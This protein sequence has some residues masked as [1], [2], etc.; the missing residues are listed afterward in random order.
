MTMIK[1]IL[2]AKGRGYV[3]VSPNETVYSA[4]EKMAEKNIG[5][6]SLW[7][8]QRSPVSSLN[9]TMHATLY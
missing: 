5:S 8:G 6:L 4:L 9:V 1:Q 7:T 3:S 2:K